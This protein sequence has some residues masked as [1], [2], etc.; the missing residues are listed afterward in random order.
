MWIRTCIM[1]GPLGSGSEWKMCNKVK[2]TVY[3]FIFAD[4]RARKCQG[5]K[6]E[7]TRRSCLYFN[8]SIGNC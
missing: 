7:D 6:G 3:F 5:P 2:H 1:V 4:H 8:L